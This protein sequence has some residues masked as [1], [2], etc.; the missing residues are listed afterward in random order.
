MRID[1][2]KLA[3]KAIFAATVFFGATVLWL[4]LATNAEAAGGD[5][6][7]KVPTTAPL[8]GVTSLLNAVTKPVGD[9]AQAASTAK[10]ASN[11]GNAA[12]APTPPAVTQVVSQTA[13]K[14]VS[15]QATAAKLLGNGA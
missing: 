15:T 3:F 7:S 12:G 8:S 10:P 1:L 9:L 6:L 11:A 13:S 4:M 5:S 14:T 2:G